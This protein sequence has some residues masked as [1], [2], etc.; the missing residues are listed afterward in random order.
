MRSV[1]R[2]L[3]FDVT[4]EE[5]FEQMKILLDLDETSLQGKPNNGRR[6]YII[7]D[8]SKVTENL[9][10]DIAINKSNES[11]DRVVRYEEAVDLAA[12]YSCNYLEMNLA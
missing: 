1:G 12:D 10:K 2:F 9:Y 5:S 11:Y 8:T 3:I 4:T 6:F 7:G